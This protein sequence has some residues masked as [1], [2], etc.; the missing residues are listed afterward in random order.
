MLILADMCSKIHNYFFM[1]SYRT[2][3]VNGAGDFKHCVFHKSG[4]FIMTTVAF[5]FSLE[6][7]QEN[8][9]VHYV[10]ARIP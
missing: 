3:E 5:L 1:Y 10:W 2:I 7:I 6:D 9:Y 8:D 4:L